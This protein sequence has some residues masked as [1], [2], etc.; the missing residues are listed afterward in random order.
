MSNTETYTPENLELWSTPSS[1]FG[2]PWDDHYVFLGQ[3]RDSDCLSRSNFIKGLEA[4][5]GETETVHVVREGHWAVGWIEWIAIHKD[6][7]EALR[8]ADE[9]N[10]ALSDY[11]VLD[12]DHYSELESEEAQ[13]VWENCYNEQ[14]RIEYIRK[15]R[16][17]FEFYN[18]ADL[19]GC[20]RGKYFL[21]YANELLY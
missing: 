15:N 10:A 18:F 11:P 13:E 20:V 19:L 5:G 2:T 4:I 17:Q 12:E 16:D 14:E 1:W 7:F 9:I 21:G 8:V 6:D 3:T